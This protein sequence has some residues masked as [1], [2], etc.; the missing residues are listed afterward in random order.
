MSSILISIIIIIIIIII[1][2]IIVNYINNKSKGGLITLYNKDT[3][4]AKKIDDLTNKASHGDKEFID[5][6][7]NSIRDTLRA[8]LKN[9]NIEPIDLDEEQINMIFANGMNGQYEYNKKVIANTLSDVK[10]INYYNKF[11][12]LFYKKFDYTITERNKIWYNISFSI[13]EFLIIFLYRYMSSANFTV[14]ECLAKGS[15]N[16]VYLGKLY[17]QNIIIRVGQSKIITDYIGDDEDEFDEYKEGILR[18]SELIKFIKNNN[19][20]YLPKIIYS[21]YDYVDKG[22]YNKNYQL[23]TSWSILPVYTNVKY[24]DTIPIPQNLKVKYPNKYID[25]KLVYMNSVFEASKYLLER[26]L[27]YYDWKYGNMMYNSETK[28]F[29]L[30]DFDITSVKIHAHSYYAVKYV[31]SNYKNNNELI[32]LVSIIV[33]IINYYTNNNYDKYKHHFRNP[34]N[35]KYKKHNENKYL[36]DEYINL[37]NKISKIKHKNI[38]EQFIYD[39]VLNSNNDNFK[40]MFNVN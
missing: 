31:I 27:F 15:Y 37:F 5:H 24:H 12:D 22:N 36:L 34:I 26:G 25:Y 11:K 30:V 13:I 17:G 6:V 38:C 10:I 4:I 7:S 28:N 2:T 14:I 35:K 8:I 1:F 9:P 18:T 32:M 20:I 33:D 3:L 16:V 21:I 39:I 40:N 23:I 29:V 19:C